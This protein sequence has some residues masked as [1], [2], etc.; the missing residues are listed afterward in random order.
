MREEEKNSQVQWRAAGAEL[1]KSD[2]VT[3]AEK[4][5]GGSPWSFLRQRPGRVMVGDRGKA[6]S[7]WPP[8]L[9]VT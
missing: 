5:E 8:R 4:L 3:E 9:I 1:Y 7:L 6:G 2:G